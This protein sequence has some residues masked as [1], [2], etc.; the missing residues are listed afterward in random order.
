MAVNR[1]MHFFQDTVVRGAGKWH[2]E[3]GQISSKPIDTVL[4]GHQHDK[5]SSN[6]LTNQ[7]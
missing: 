5:H 2:D 7:V 4:G 1:N 6:M 3:R